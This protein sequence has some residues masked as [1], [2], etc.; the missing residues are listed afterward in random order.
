[1][2]EVIVL[3][4]DE[5]VEIIEDTVNK[6]LESE[7]HR[8]EDIVANS[9][10][11]NTDR[12]RWLSIEDLMNYIPTHPSR[13]TIYRWTMTKSIPYYK[14]GRSL[15]FKKSDIDQW[16]DCSRHKTYEEIR[17]EARQQINRRSV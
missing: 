10:D 4:K 11:F 12:D 3:T 6:K 8:R 5:L 15:Q 1:M 16:L 13:Q 17:E 9:E 14:R 7:R 2:S